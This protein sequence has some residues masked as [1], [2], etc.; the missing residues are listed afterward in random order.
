MYFTWKES[1]WSV[2]TTLQAT[3]GQ[4]TTTSTGSFPLR[5]N[6][7]LKR[8]PWLVLPGVLFQAKKL[9]WAP[10]RPGT[11]ASSPSMVTGTALETGPE[12]ALWSA[13]WYIAPLPPGPD[14]QE[15]VGYASTPRWGT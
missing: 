6:G 14:P 4:V 2:A 15:L 11:S 9:T 3:R 8:L 12:A 10:V 1:A 7:S 13:N 5:R